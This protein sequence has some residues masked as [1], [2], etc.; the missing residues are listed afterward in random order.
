MSQDALAAKSGAER[1]AGKDQLKVGA[2]QSAGTGQAT[3]R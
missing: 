3:R 2:G 1:L